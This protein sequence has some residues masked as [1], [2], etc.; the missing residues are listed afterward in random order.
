MWRPNPSTKGVRRQPCI[1][2]V[3]IPKT[4]IC[5]LTKIFQKNSTIPL[6]HVITQNPKS[7]PKP[8]Q[9]SRTQTL[10]QTIKNSKPQKPIF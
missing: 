7:N 10:N 9:T 2:L 4:T 5:P 1:G 6:N 8:N 3:T